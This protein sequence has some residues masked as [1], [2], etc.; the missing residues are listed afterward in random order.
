M[1]FCSLSFPRENSLYARSSPPRSFA[2]RPGRHRQHR[3]PFLS[4][5]PDFPLRRPVGVHIR[6]DE[7]LCRSS[8]SKKQK[9]RNT[10]EHIRCSLM[11]NNRPP[12]RFIQGAG[13]WGGAVSQLVVLL[14]Q[15][16]ST[17]FIEATASAG[18]F[19]S[20]TMVFQ[21]FARYPVSH[22]PESASMYDMSGTAFFR[23]S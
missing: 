6:G 23:Y 3:S 12:D 21:N 13:F 17:L 10:M 7:F 9:K 15:D 8:I 1:Y 18:F 11:K 19:L 22:Q 2:K 20:T 14:I 4:V 5:C 16:S